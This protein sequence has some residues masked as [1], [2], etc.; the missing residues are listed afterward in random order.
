MRIQ[1]E[2]LMLR[3]PTFAGVI[4]LAL[5]VLSPRVAEAQQPETF[6]CYVPD[7]GA[8]YLIKLH[9]LPTACLSATHVEIT[10]V[11][12]DPT[13]GSSTASSN[14]VVFVND[15][16]AT[17]INICERIE[18]G[19]GITLSESDTHQYQ[20]VPVY[21]SVVINVAIYGS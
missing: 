2:S 5:G 20:V 3:F 7:V 9:G 11:G 8:I 14:D 6:A 13:Y 16:V 15:A 1:S 12:G 21:H 19:V 10:L 4:A 17:Y 18:V